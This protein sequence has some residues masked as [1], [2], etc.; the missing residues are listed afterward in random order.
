MVAMRT[1]SKALSAVRPVKSGMT[2]EGWRLPRVLRTLAMTEKK[3][4]VKNFDYLVHEKAGV[5]RAGD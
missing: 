1:K 5:L 2:K 3:K 4:V